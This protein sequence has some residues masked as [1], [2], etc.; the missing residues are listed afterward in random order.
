MARFTVTLGE[1]TAEI[2]DVSPWLTR[3]RLR[4]WEKSVHSIIDRITMDLGE[5][6]TTTELASDEPGCDCDDEDCE[7]STVP[8]PAIGFRSP[9]GGK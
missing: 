6:V 8:R 5:L 3:F 4:A 9:V 2:R 1:L 7:C